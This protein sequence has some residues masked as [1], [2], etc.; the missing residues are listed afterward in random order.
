MI[1]EK[2][3][4]LPKGNQR[5]GEWPLKKEEFIPLGTLSQAVLAG[6]VGFPAAP[7]TG[8]LT[9]SMV[10][11]LSLTGPYKNSEGDSHLPCMQALKYSR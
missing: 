10:L 9:L 6:R 11:F 7:D 4:L 2:T 8:R 5:R 1:P 3:M